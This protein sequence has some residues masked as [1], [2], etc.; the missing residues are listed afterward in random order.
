[1]G[2]RSVVAV[3]LCLALFVTVALVVRSSAIPVAQIGIPNVN[4]QVERRF[5]QL[6]QKEEGERMEKENRRDAQKIVSLAAELK[7]YAT[8]EDGA[9]P[10]DAIRRA[11]QVAKLARRLHDRLRESALR[12]P[13]R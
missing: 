7:Q 5:Q 2:V 3:G 11:E 10:A 12:L 6:R 9:P 13:A 1:M 4:P 8:S